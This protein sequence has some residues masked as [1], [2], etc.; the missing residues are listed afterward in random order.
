MEER[1]QGNLFC[2]FPYLH[3]D[4]G[5]DRLTSACFIDATWKVPL[6]SWHEIHVSQSIVSSHLMELD[7]TLGLS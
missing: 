7:I 1:R 2:A 4:W 3:R 6:K 5:S